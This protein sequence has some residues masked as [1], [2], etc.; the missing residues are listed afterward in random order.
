MRA[1]FDRHNNSYAKYQILFEH[2]AVD[3]ITV[4]FKG[5]I[6]LKQYIPK[7]HTWFGMKLYKLW[8]SEEYTYHMT[9]YLDKDRKCETPWQLHM[10]LL[11]GLAAGT[12]HMRHKLYMDSFLLSSALFDDLRTK[13]INYC[14]SVRPNRKGMPENLEHKMQ[15]KRG[16]LKNKVKGN[17]TARV[18]KEKRNVNVLTNMHSP[19]LDGNFCGEHGKAVKLAIIQIYISR[20]RGICGKIWLHV[21]LS[22]SRWT[23]KWT[24]KLFF[25]LLNLTTLNS[26]IILTSCGSKLLHRQFKL[27]LVR[28]LI[29]E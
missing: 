1:I 23:W 28:D 24:K 3:E 27:T 25:H 16:N 19:L 13:A 2:L 15:L 21:K 9:V 17:L 12:E 29:Q 11:K 26:F 20:T 7:K 10:Q 4:F 14:G 22:I 6:I 5:R 18:W 8:D